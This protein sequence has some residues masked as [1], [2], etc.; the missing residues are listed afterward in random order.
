MRKLKTVNWEKIITQTIE[1]IE[2]ETL[3]SGDGSDSKNTPP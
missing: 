1:P 3:P 2:F